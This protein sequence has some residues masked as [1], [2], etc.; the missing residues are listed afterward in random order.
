[1][2]LAIMQPY[3]FPYLGYYALVGQVDRFVFLDDVRY[4]KQGWINRN[5]WMVGL[6]PQYF[7]VPAQGIGE[8]SRI[9]EVSVPKDTTWRRKLLATLKQ[10]YSQAPRTA[11]VLRLFR[12]V[13]EGDSD[14][15]SGMAK[16]SVVAVAQS[17]GMQASFVM[18][19]TIYENDALAGE[20]RVL[21]I[22]RREGATEYVNLPGGLALYDPARFAA[23]GV[24]LRFV[25]PWVRAYPRG[26]GAPM[27]HLSV[28][29]A[30]MFNEP[31]IL[32]TLIDEESVA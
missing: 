4:I 8:F 29:D 27:P 24:A 21:D 26:A 2:R 6:E 25:A 22:C 5:R 18:S 7:T 11:E 23:H 20:D 1:M 28:L 17:M 15:I 32:R 3:L 10:S 9:N 12:D 31:Q 30:L 19:S 16:R 14:A 13:L